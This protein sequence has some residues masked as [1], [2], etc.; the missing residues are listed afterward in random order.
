MRNFNFLVVCLML[1]FLS[2]SKD[3]I[4]I[5][6]THLP[7]ETQGYNMLLIG[8]SFFKPYAEKLDDLSILAG[9][10]NHSSTRIT[11]GGENGRPINF[12]NDSDSNEHI[13]IKAALDAGNIDVF[14]MT[15]GHET[16]DRTEGHRS[17]I[18]YALQN[19]PNITIFIAIPQID[20]PADWEQRAKEYGF[21]TI[22]ELYDYFVNDIVH[23]EIVDQLRDEFPSTEIFTIPTGWTSVKLDQ[24]NRD[25]EL[26]DDIARF[27]PQ[28]TSLFTDNKG[29][30]G[31]IIRETGSLLWL[32]SIYG[33]DLSTFSYEIGF[34]TDLHEIAKQIMD[35]HD[36][37]Y[38][39]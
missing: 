14:G 9:F 19:N 4:L 12:W 22:Q 28:P 35:S 37:N 21:D 15:A 1:V 30:Q 29:H 10:E 23:H 20:F 38:K 33:V 13:Q 18:N 26:L 7:V 36:S 5:E 3:E 39:L 2:C 16:E 6:E 32:S 31:N 24:M 11:R 27:G 25:N 8:N 34:N 17:W